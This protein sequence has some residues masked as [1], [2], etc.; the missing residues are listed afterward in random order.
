MCPCPTISRPYGHRK[1]FI[2]ILP[3]NVVMPPP[4]QTFQKFND[5]ALAACMPALEA[6]LF[7]AVPS[8]QAYTGPDTHPHHIPHRLIELRGCILSV[9][10]VQ[11]I[12]AFPRLTV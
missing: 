1:P 3:K 10:Q 11:H 4:Y 12:R 2:S 6:K 9:G 8:E 7:L 5:P